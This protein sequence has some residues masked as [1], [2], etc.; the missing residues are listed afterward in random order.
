MEDRW[1]AGYMCAVAM[2]INKQG[3]VNT[4][5]RE[6]FS[7]G[8]GKKSLKELEKL[9]VDKADIE[10]FKKHKKELYAN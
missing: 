5:C 6:L 1:I 9:G 3:L 4:E 10:L 2:L 7:E 8:G